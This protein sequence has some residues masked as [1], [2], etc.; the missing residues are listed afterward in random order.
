VAEKKKNSFRAQKKKKF[1]KL[2]NEAQARFWGLG[3]AGKLNQEKKI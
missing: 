3:L 1:E 2:K